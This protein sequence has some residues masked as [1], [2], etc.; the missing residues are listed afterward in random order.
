M[1]RAIASLFLFLVTGFSASSSAALEDYFFFET[2]WGEEIK[3]HIIGTIDDP[4]YI[5]HAS[6]L[7][8]T[9]EL[10]RQLVKST[11]E[12]RNYRYEFNTCFD[13]Q[14][15]YLNTK[16]EQKSEI[17]VNTPADTQETLSVKPITPSA[18][19]TKSAI[20]SKTD[21]ANKY[22]EAIASLLGSRTVEAVL[23]KSVENKSVVTSP[24]M[25]ML[26]QDGRPIA[27]CKQTAEGCLQLDE[28]LLTNF[29]KGGWGASYPYSSVSNS[30]ERAFSQQIE[31]ALDRISQLHY[32]CNV[33]YTG[34]HGQPMVAQMICFLSH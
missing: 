21:L 9:Q 4:E 27:M 29:E 10:A 19:K 5:I 28:V 7:S 13:C 31:A 14:V 26:A 18:E 17:A 8:T 33:V 1:K 22:F 12:R 24:L 3:V 11:M 34:I 20:V 6:T 23:G 16:Q 30:A 2:D 32:T 15:S 25:I